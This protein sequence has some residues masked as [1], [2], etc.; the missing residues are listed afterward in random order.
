MP[1]YL[2]VIDAPVPTHVGARASSI[3]RHRGHAALENAACENVQ[4][5]IWIT[6]EHDFS[7][8]PQLLSTK[9]FNGSCV[10]SLMVQ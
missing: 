6:S 7:V 4:E 1:G 9:T 5:L 10:Q 3:E 8:L 2:T